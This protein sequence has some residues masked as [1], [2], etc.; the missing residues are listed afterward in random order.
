MPSIT[1]SQNTPVLPNMRRMVMRPSG[2]SWSR[3]NS[4]KSSLAT[5]LL[6]LVERQAEPEQRHVQDNGALAGVL[7]RDLERRAAAHRRQ[8]LV[9]ERQADEA[10][11]RGAGLDRLLLDRPVVDLDLDGLGQIEAE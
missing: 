1:P 3:R 9:V 7:H 6:G 10:A 5:I 2:A 4:A 11:G 8:E